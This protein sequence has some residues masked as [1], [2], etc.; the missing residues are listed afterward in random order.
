MQM[1]RNTLH[2]KNSDQ[3]VAWM[4]SKGFVRQKAIGC[5]ESIRLK[6]GKEL[7]IAYERLS[8]DHHTVQAPYDQYVRDWLRSKKLKLKSQM[9]G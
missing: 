4:L 5:Y 1:S 2:K 6:R 9:E 3:F 8:G 7:F